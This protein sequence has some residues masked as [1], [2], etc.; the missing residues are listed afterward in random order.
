[1]EKMEKNGKKWKKMEKMEKMGKKWKKWKKMEKMAI[2][3]KKMAKKIWSSS[4]KILETT[5][6]QSLR[7]LSVSWGEMSTFSFYNR[8]GVYILSYNLSN[9]SLNQG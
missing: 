1:M 7:S 2:N 5:L 6:H 8:I 3:G 4:F 9:I